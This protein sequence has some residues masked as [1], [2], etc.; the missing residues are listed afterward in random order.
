MINSLLY[1]PRTSQLL[2]STIPHERHN[3]YLLRSP[4]TSHDQAEPTVDRLLMYYTCV[5][6]ERHEDLP[7]RYDDPQRTRPCSDDSI[8]YVDGETERLARR[9]H[10]V[11]YYKL[12]EQNKNLEQELRFERS[13]QQV[14]HL[15]YRTL[16]K[17]QQPMSSLITSSFLQNR[18]FEPADCARQLRSPPAKWRHHPAGSVGIDDPARLRG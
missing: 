10:Q 7:L 1:T 9:F 5:S 13:K 18:Y 11:E 15:L 16:N 3:P 8:I 12:Q 17:H 2:R 4:T 6:A 14:S